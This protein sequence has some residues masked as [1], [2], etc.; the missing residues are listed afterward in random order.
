MAIPKVIKNF[1][2]FLAGVGFAGLCD[3]VKLP[4]LKIKAE[5]HR[6]GGMDIPVDLDMGMEKLELG[7][8]M[9]EQH[10][11]VFRQFGLRNQNAVQA[12][13]RASKVNDQISE[14]YVIFARGMYTSVAGG[15]VKNGEKA[16]LEATLTLRYYRLVMANKPLIEID[17]DNMIRIIDGV[18][19]LASIRADIGIG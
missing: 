1:N 19:Q 17:A 12:T 10:A 2:M 11:D 7:F 13:F 8:T 3:A 5:E 4:E 15:D 9:A 14:P 6:A 18:D 16:V